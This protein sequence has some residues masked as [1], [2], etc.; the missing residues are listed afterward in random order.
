MMNGDLT[1]SQNEADRLSI[2]NQVLSKKIT[3][4]ESS[5]LL[6]LSENFIPTLK[7]KKRPQKSRRE[8][9]S[10]FREMIQ[11][12]GSHHDWFDGEETNVACIYV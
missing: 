8:R 9:R 3:A 12:D 4:R 5:L 10:A 2:I 7:R 1:M 6:K 11:F